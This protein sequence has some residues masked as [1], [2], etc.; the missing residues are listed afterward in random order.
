MHMQTHFC[1]V[2]SVSKLRF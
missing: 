1:G 2:I